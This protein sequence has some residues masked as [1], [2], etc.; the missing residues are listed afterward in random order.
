MYS[1]QY[2]F[3]NSFRLRRSSDVCLL[4]STLREEHLNFWKSL[5][6]F[7]RSFINLDFKKLLRVEWYTY[8]ISMNDLF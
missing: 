6:T 7:L 2:W 8:L 3:Q 1:S 5:L 4:K